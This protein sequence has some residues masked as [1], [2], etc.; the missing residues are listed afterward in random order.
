MSG[1]QLQ[2]AAAWWQARKRSEQILLAVALVVGLVMGMQRLLVVPLKSSQA[3]LT[4]Q[5]DS[6]HVQLR[7]LRQ[8]REKLASVGPEQ[9][10]QLQARTRERLLALRDE[11]A[12]TREAMAQLRSGLVPADSMA[13]VLGG[14]LRT[15]RG[16]QLA[17]VMN[18]PV[19]ALATQAELATQPA[20]ANTKA[21]P[22]QKNSAGQTGA[23]PAAESHIEVAVPRL[24][25]H[26]MRII[27]RGRYLEIA[28]YLAAV[29][30]LPW[31]VYLDGLI[32]EVESYPTVEATLELHTLSEDEAWFFTS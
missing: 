15:H 9:I 1:E 22:A 24:Y 10:Q 16:V 4:K 28:K 6:Q 30:E 8:L 31:R 29:E 27:L 21:K 17:E 11:L 23:T 12:Q 13:D 7:Q 25:K 5:L 32:L 2:K 18:L 19:V 26:P 14:L 20:E 3:G